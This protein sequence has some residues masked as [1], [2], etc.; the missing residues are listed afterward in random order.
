M[1]NF[2]IKI[3]SVILWLTILSTWI[4]A[5]SNI[6]SLTQ[7]V[8][9]WDIISAEYY[10]NLNWPKQEWKF[11]KYSGWKLVCMD[12]IEA[13]SW[14]YVS[15]S[16]DQ[17]VYW[18]KTFDFGVTVPSDWDDWKMD[19]GNNDDKL[20]FSYNGSAKYSID[21]FGNTY[22][23]DMYV[24]DSGWIWGFVSS[25][26]QEDWSIALNAT[27]LDWKVTWNFVS[28]WI[29][30]WLRFVW[31]WGQKFGVNP[32]WKISASST[33]TPT[34]NNH[35]TTKK[36]VDDAVGWFPQGLETSYGWDTRLIEAWDNWKLYFT[37]NGTKLYSLHDT[38]SPSFDWDLVP[39][40]YVDERIIVNFWTTGVYYSCLTNARTC[41]SWYLQASSNLRKCREGY[42]YIDYTYSRICIKL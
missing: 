20:Y 7:P 37:H 31:K 12:D 28:V 26:T 35:L 8:S 36:Y 24:K 39:K 15:L 27:W 21:K 41:P 5:A 14:S 11:C 23:E 10:N 19:W 1:K 18:T 33:Y 34:L 25:S 6:T 30:E 32:D 17:T 2:K 22:S 42:S 4:Y 16:W 38:W 29:Y 3:L 9:D 13:W 40:K